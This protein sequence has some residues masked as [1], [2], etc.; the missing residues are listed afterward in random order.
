MLMHAGIAFHFHFLCVLISCVPSVWPLYCLC[1]PMQMCGY[2]GPLYV[3]APLP[4]SQGWGLELLPLTF[5]LGLTFMM[6][7]DVVEAHVTA[8]NFLWGIWPIHVAKRKLIVGHFDREGFHQQKQELFMDLCGRNDL[9]LTSFMLR[10]LLRYLRER[11]WFAAY[12]QQKLFYT[13]T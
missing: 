11:V 3:C 2:M 10:E 12:C 1:H 13:Y 5:S 6:C 8:T 4:P 7:C 9:L